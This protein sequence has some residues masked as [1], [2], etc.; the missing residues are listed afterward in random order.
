MLLQL[1]A[2]AIALTVVAWL[3]LRAVRNAR[4]LNQRIE[5]YRKEQEEKGPTDPYSALAELLTEDHERKKGRGE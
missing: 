2:I 1:A 3:V 4:R 5:E